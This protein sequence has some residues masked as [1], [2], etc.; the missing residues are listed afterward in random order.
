MIIFAVAFFDCQKLK[1]F[2]NLSFTSD[3]NI[4]VINFFITEKVIKHSCHGCYIFIAAEAI[5][6]SNVSIAL[7]YYFFSHTVKY[8]IFKYSFLTA[9]K[10]I[11]CDE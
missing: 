10:T 3:K 2:N 1:I 5:K 11:K 7:F 9:K 8:C 6:M 4:M